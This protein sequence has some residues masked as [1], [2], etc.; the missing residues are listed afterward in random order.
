MENRTIKRIGFGTRLGAY[1]IDMLLCWLLSIIVAVA[2]GVISVY[3]IGFGNDSETVG[4]IFGIL[5]AVGIIIN[6][7]FAAVVLM[8][9]VTGQTPGKMMLGIKNANADATKAS[10]SV[11]SG[12]AGIKFI[13]YIFRLISF[14]TGIAMIGSLG[15]IAGFIIIAGCLLVLGKAKQSVH[16][17]IFKTAVFKTRAVL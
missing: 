9:A 15:T 1:L 4:G 17:R 13:F 10:I 8:E 14:L 5:I 16:D 6:I 12:R 7:L 11:L 2:T 3:D